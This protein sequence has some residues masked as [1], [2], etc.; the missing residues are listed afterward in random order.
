M[1]TSRSLANKQMMSI[2]P[3]SRFIAKSA[4]QQILFI[5]ICYLQYFDTY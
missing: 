3:N 4:K 2:S 5:V 1:Y